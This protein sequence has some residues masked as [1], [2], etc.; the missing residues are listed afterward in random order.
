[1][2]N[3]HRSLQRHFRWL[4]VAWEA[5]LGMGLVLAVVWPFVVFFKDI[6][7]T[8]GNA[9]FRRSSP[10]DNAILFVVV[11]A[12]LQQAFGI[13]L[14]VH[15]VQRARRLDLRAICAEIGR[16]G[17]MAPRI[18]GALASGM[19][20]APGVLFITMLCASRTAPAL[21]WPCAVTWLCWA[22]A[23]N[24]LA[25]PRGSMRS[26]WDA[27]TAWLAV[28]A[29]SAAALYALRM[30]GDSALTS[31]TTWAVLLLSPL[32]PLMLNLALCR[33]VRRDLCTTS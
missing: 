4:A 31:M 15:A 19:I 32:P 13:A 14:V 22:V 25:F 21:F 12:V 11:T 18:G 10:E 23:V 29:L 20:A 26:A 2:R 24:P 6:T 5:L 8:L 16:P 9:V 7:D 30:A 28:V 3:V 17:A 1:M 27:A 33:M